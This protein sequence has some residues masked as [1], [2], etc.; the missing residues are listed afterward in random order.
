MSKYIGD[1]GALEADPS[2]GARRTVP[3]RSAPSYGLGVGITK[4]LASGGKGPQAS[5]A[6]GGMRHGKVSVAS[7][8]PQ[9]IPVHK[10]SMAQLR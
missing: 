8:C 1:D 4:D 10:G 2:P 6:D 9:S 5:W 7:S 3:A